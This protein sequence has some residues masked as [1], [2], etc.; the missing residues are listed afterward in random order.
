MDK[1]SQQISS[2]ACSHFPGAAL[3]TLVPFPTD[4]Y[5]K[6]LDS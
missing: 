4:N 2:I 5:N 3:A 6:V 1:V